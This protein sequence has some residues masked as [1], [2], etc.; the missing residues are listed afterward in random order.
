MPNIKPISDLRN[1]TEVL[2]E[3]DSSNRV[4]LTRNGHGEYAILSMAEIDKLD[5]YKAAYKLFAKLK[6][7]ERRA[8]VEGWVDAEELEKE[9]GLTED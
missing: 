6:N 5:R 7:A 1:Y 8:E 3:V 4:Y 9:L 2:K